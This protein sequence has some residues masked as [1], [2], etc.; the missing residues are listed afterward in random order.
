MARTKQTARRP[1]RAPVVWRSVSSGSKWRQ[2]RS[3]LNA[4]R[5]ELRKQVALFPSGY[6][7]NKQMQLAATLGV[8]ES[9]ATPVAPARVATSVFPPSAAREPNRIP[10]FG[11]F[12]RMGLV[13]PFSDFFLAVLESFGLKLLNHTPDAIVDL[14][15]FAYA[16][17]S[18]VGV[19][20]SMALFRHYFYA[21][22]CKEGWIG[23]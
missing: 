14:T 5:A 8:I 18:F 6:D 16:Y 4:H 7:G 21:R 9:E 10:I 11:V 12:M 17:E 22:A 23:G 19:A 20:P 1:S 13:P 2:R 15:L 3:A